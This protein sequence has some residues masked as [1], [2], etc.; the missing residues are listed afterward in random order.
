MGVW[1]T[2]IKKHTKR[3]GIYL[4]EAVEE[5]ISFGWVD[6][7]LKVIDAESYRLWFSPRKP[8]SIWSKNNK[9]RVEKLL[10][11]GLMAPPGLEKVEAAKKDGSWNRLDVVEELRVPDDLRMAL[12][13]DSSALKNFGAFNDSTKKQLLWWIES[14]KTEETRNRRI[15]SIV[16]M[17]IQNKKPV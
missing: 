7:Q 13:E 15:A 10:A 2:V 11:Q 8:G 16:E 17:A 6:S 3:S 9:Q 12:S 4:D 5:A 14:A 1:L